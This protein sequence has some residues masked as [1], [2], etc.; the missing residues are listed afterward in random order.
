MAGRPCFPHRAVCC[1]ALERSRPSLF[2]RPYCAISAIWLVGAGEVR[3]DPNEVQGRST[4]GESAY[5]CR[6]LFNPGSR[7]PQSLH[8]EFNNYACTLVPLRLREEHRRK[9]DRGQRDT[10]TLLLSRSLASLLLIVSI[11]VVSHPRSLGL[12]LIP[13]K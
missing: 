6:P 1:D 12:H 3:N 9:L 2:L 5:P 7:C 4:S 10:A 11:R 8:T 13:T